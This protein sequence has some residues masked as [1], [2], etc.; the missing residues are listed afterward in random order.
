MDDGFRHPTFLTG[1]RSKLHNTYNCAVVCTHSVIGCLHP[2]QGSSRL[3]TLSNRP[4]GPLTFAGSLGTE[5]EAGAFVP[6]HPRP[7]GSGLS[8]VVSVVVMLG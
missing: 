4:L 6:C 7:A 3:A 8:S 5:Q 1:V 2:R